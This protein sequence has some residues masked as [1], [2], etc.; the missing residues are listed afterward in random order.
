[1]TINA[2]AST[3]LLLYQLVAEEQ[4]VNGRVRSAARFRTTS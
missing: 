1:M 2:T 3:L 4:G